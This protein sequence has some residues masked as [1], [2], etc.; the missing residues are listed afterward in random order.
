[1]AEK[2]AVLMLQLTQSQQVVYIVSKEQMRIRQ[3]TNLFRRVV[4]GVLQWIQD[5]ARGKIVGLNIPMGQLV[6]VGFVKD[7]LCTM[8]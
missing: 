6:E 8:V 1:M 2:S 3:D 5:N 7:S 4:L